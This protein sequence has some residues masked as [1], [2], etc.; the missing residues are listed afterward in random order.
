MNDVFVLLQPDMSS[1]QKVVHIIDIYLIISGSDSCVTYAI[2]LG[3]V[4]SE[5][6]PE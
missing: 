3:G 6:G 4:Y 1:E 2:S 5:P